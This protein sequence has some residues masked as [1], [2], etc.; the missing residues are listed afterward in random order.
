[1]GETVYKE[2]RGR[3]D[4]AKHKHVYRNASLCVPE[5]WPG[6][7]DIFDHNY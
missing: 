6:T 3:M 4:K 7:F 5:E 1:M 2:Q